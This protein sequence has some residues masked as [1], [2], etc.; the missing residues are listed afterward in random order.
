MDQLQVTLHHCGER[1]FIARQ[2][3]AAQTIAIGGLRRHSKVHGRTRRI[4]E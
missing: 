4:A 2:D 3:E 1:A